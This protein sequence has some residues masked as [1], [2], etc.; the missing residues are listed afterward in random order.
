MPNR[1]IVDQPKR[2]QL[3]TRTDLK[4]HQGRRPLKKDVEMFVV[5]RKCRTW[6]IT[7]FSLVNVERDIQDDVNVYENSDFDC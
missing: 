4:H 1:N 3:Q 7:H 6:K 5:T 2:S